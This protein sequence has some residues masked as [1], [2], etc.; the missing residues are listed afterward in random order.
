[1]APNIT[2]SPTGVLFEGENIED[3]PVEINKEKEIYKR[4]IVWRNVAIF[5]GLHIGAIYGVYLAL[6]SAK[7]LTTLF[8]FILYQCSG[9]GITA[10]AHRLWAHRSYKAKWQLRLILIIFNTIA[11]QDLCAHNLCAPAVIPKPEHM[12]SWAYDLKSVS[13]DMVKT[14]VLKSGDGTHDVWGWGDKDQTLEEKQQTIHNFDFIKVVK[15]MS[16]KDIRNVF[17][18]LESKK[19]SL[20][21]IIIEL[22]KLSEE[23]AE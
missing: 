17:L 23:E 4:R 21:E 5:S 9:I 19:I 2:S 10:G 14:R 11:F 3:Q 1:M 12:P 22:Q 20:P 13:K 18:K 8:A 15:T 7:L 16:A 6:T